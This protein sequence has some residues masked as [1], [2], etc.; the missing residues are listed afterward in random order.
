MKSGRIRCWGRRGWRS[1]GDST[2]NLRLHRESRVV[3]VYEMTVGKNGP[4]FKQSPTL[5]QLSEELKNREPHRGV[6]ATDEKGY[7]AMP[8]E[9]PGTVGRAVSWS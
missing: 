3:Q 8:P 9:I 6:S 5:A 1:P 4:K 2:F 7:P